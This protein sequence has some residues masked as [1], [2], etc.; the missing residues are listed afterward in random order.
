MSS[1]QL[2]VIWYTLQQHLSMH[3]TTNHQT[4]TGN[5][6]SSSCIIFF[7][8][9]VLLVKTGSVVL[10]NNPL[11]PDYRCTADCGWITGHSYV[12]YGPILN[13]ATVVLYEG[14]IN[15]KHIAIIY[16]HHWTRQNESK[17]LSISATKKNNSTLE[18]KNTK[19]WFGYVKRR[20]MEAISRILDQIK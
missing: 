17:K 1:I 20:T 4:S 18:F 16:M 10:F 14:V 2:V 12:T 11:I 3:L 9:E 8:F 5:F 7:I 15:L 19:N 6:E 13:G